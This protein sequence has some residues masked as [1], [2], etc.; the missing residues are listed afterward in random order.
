MNIL[1]V[2]RY[3]RFRSRVAEAYFNQINKNRNIHAASAGLIRGH[4][5]LDKNEVDA[6]RIK[7]IDISG[8]PKGLSTDLLKKTDL[9]VIVA[10][11]VPAKIFCYEDYKDYK[12]KLLVWRIKDIYDGESKVLIEK[13]IDEIKRKVEKL[14]KKLENRR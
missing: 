7:G 13:R 6:A 8:K 11:N 5:P 1:F 9:I 3:N 4:Y 14:V 2:C 12:G 10:D